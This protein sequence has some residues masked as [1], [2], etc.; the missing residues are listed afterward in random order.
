M[1]LIEVVVWMFVLVSILLWWTRLII[2]SNERSSLFFQW[3]TNES[4]KISLLN[5]SQH[6]ANNWVWS[7]YISIWTTWFILSTISWSNYYECNNYTWTL[8]QINN[9]FT[10]VFCNID[11]KWEMIYSYKLE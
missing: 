1:K 6:L 3:L 10:W 5:Y 4:E 7:W 9:Q 2:L 8:I 11:Y